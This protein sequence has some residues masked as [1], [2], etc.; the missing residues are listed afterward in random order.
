MSYQAGSPSC[1]AA[2]AAAAEGTTK[3]VL[4]G[5]KVHFQDQSKETESSKWKWKERRVSLDLDVLSYRDSSLRKKQRTLLQLTALST[6]DMLLPGDMSQASSIPENKQFLL[7]V[8][9]KTVDSNYC[10]VVFAFSEVGDR[11]EWQSVLQQA[12]LVIGEK[13]E[14]PNVCSLRMKP[15]RAKVPQ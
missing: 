11:E 5:D 13:S 2:G 7:K 6:V 15:W 14:T 1:N 10:V 3:E 12:I 8:K 4:R 9:G